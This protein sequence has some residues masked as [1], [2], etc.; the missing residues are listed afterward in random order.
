MILQIVNSIQKKY[1]TSTL[2]QFICHFLLLALGIFLFGFSQPNL[3]LPKGCFIFS[4]IAYIPIFILTLLLPWKTVWLYGFF[5]GFGCYCFYTYWLATFHSLGIIVIAGMFGLQCVFE[6]LLLK[7]VTILFKKNWWICQWIIWCAYEYV[8]TLGFTGFHYGLTAY[9]HWQI[10]PMIQVA[11]IFSVWGLNAFISFF[12]ALLACFFVQYSSLRQF[13]REKKVY[14]SLWVVCL[15]SILIYGFVSPVHYETSPKKTVA[16]IQQN[17][18]PWKGGYSTYKKDL[19]TLKKLSDE[20]LQ[21]NSQIDLVVWPE[22]AFVPRIEWHYKQR[23]D[24]DKFNLVQDLLLYLDSKEVPF[25]IGND[26]YNG[27]DDFNSVLYFTPKKNVIPPKPEMYFKMRLVPFTEY[28]PYKKLFPRIY[29]LLIDFD[30]HLWEPGTNPIV[31]T[32]DSAQFGTPICFE[33]TFGYISRRFVNNGADFLVNIS[34]DAWSKSLACQYQHLSMA[35]F[36]SIEN[37][38]S[39]VRATASGQTAIIDPNGKILAM[40]EPFKETYLVGDFPIY[41][42]EKTLYT[43]FGDYLGVLFF[44]L[45]LGIILVGIIRKLTIKE[46]R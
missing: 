25:V 41:K 36:R 38:V 14:I 32:L 15:F 39:S 22:T 28:F 12:S 45:A 34:N 1:K 5:Y 2:F 16:L 30:T 37:R 10:L 21:E 18:D 20:A 7:L 40:A 24:R 33:D 42:G 3:F 29:Q 27:V 44:M 11:D 46:N 17:S 6:F 19:A 26:Y 8:K 31:F 35:V 23:N 4:Y 9:S 13:I 43:R